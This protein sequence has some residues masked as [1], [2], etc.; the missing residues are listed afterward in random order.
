MAATYPPRVAHSVLA[1]PV[2]ALEPYV[3]GRWEHYDPAWVSRDPAFTHAHI[4]ALAPF[5]TTPGAA[6]LERV[7]EIA[8]T[9]PAFDFTLDEIAAFPDGI[10]HLLP[11]PATPFAELTARLWRAFPEC[12][13]YE[14]QFGDVVPH[15]TL[16]RLAPDVSVASVAADLTGLLPVRTRADRLE[17]QWYDEGECRVL[18]AWPF[19]RP[20]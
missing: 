13:P 3:R 12:P 10:V 9:T 20:G 7:A 6:D 5:V 19:G 16:D 18:W 15:L 8:R 17:L 1:V 14:G 11:A 2:P 4:T